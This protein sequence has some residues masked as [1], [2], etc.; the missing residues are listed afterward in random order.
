MKIGSV[1]MSHGVG[2]L[3]CKKVIHAVP[4]MFIN[5]DAK[6]GEIL[7][8]CTIINILEMAKNKGLQSISIPSFPK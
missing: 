7:Y 4:P 5:F 8:T 2:K 3:G 6:V 1:S